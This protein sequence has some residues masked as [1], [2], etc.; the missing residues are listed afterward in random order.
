MVPEPEV[1]DQ[2]LYVPVSP[3][4]DRGSFATIGASG[5]DVRV[6][7]ELAGDALVA[8]NGMCVGVIDV[9]LAPNAAAKF[10]REGGPVMSN[11]VL[12]ETVWPDVTND[13]CPNRLRVNARFVA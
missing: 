7:S 4:F 3:G 13:V 1:I 5:L 9:K 6:K 10:D 12:G 8:F 2:G 11:V